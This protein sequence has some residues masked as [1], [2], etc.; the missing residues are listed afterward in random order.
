MS[1]VLQGSE[2]RHRE[3][4]ASSARTR[5]VSFRTHDQYGTPQCPRVP[6]QSSP[7]KSRAERKL[8]RKTLG[9]GYAIRIC[10]RRVRP[11]AALLRCSVVSCTT[12]IPRHPV[13]QQREIMRDARRTGA[14]PAQAFE[15]D[16]SR[17][18][19]R[20]RQ[21]IVRSRTTLRRFG[22]AALTE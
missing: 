11:R 5:V 3:S 4:S 10:A 21:H 14:S 17:K 19:G 7:G 16:R 1:N 18:T 6:K 9:T 13:V 12:I 20:P 8:D 22:F 2:G 15:S